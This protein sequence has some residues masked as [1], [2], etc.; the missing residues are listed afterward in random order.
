MKPLSA[1]LLCLA[2]TSAS[3]DAAM[4]DCIDATCRITAPDGGF[5]TGVVYHRD[6]D[7]VWVLTNAH[8]AT[9][10][11]LT[12]EFWRDGH[13]SRKVPGHTVMRNQALDTAVIAVDAR[14]F[15]E[16]LPVAIPIAAASYRAQPGQAVTSVGCVNG[17][18]ATGWKGHVLRYYGSDMWFLPPPAGGRSGSAIFDAEGTKIIG[19]LRACVEDGSTMWGAA[20]SSQ[21]L[22][23]L[24]REHNTQ[25]AP[26]CESEDCPT[27]NDSTW[28]LS[29]YRANQD[30]L[31]QA[32]DDRIDSL[33]PTMPK[34]QSRPMVPVDVTPITTETPTPVDPCLA[35]EL[36]L[37]MLERQLK[38]RYAVLEQL[39][40]VKCSQQQNYQLSQTDISIIVG[41]VL[42]QMPPVMFE[43]Q[44][45]NGEVFSQSKPL[46]EAIRLRLVPR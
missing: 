34:Q 7:K 29:P 23:R 12:L 5:G 33:Y 24:F 45:P 15:G 40:K 39:I 28:R 10:N 13:Q 8:I 1:F 38:A 44:H 37:A 26:V 18:W 22:A 21:A 25:Y 11:A 30:R 20:T 42:K 16:M 32:Q 4:T 14:L 36:R 2:A 19:L 41:E 17:G 31:N 9:A 3:A 35:I 27:S 46:G 6:A 43:I